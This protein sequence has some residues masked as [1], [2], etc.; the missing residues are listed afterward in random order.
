M[1][2]GISL[3]SA[4]PGASGIEATRWTVE[5][6]RA[7]S[8]AGLTSLT[9][10][11]HH[12][13]G[14]VPYVQNAP[15]LGRLLAEWDARPI[16]C[17]FLVPAWNPVLMAEQIGTLAAMAEGPFIVQTGLGDRHQLAVMGADVPHRGHRLETSVGLVKALL[18]GER[19]DDEEL[20]IRG[21]QIA[22][23]PP[24]EVEWWIGAESTPGLVR[25][26]RLGDAWYAGPTLDAA[27][28]RDAMARYHRA[29]DEEGREPGR[30]ALRKDV[31]IA[32]DHASAVATG[33]ALLDAGY[34]GMTRDQVVVGGPDQVAEQ[35]ARFAEIGFTDVIIRTMTVPQP[36]ALRSI[37]LAGR[38][39][40][41]LSS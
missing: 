37:E 11:D 24:R 19:V 36:D 33:G 22:P 8:A 40:D 27:G 31:F 29:C 3:A 35:L 16:G 2:I 28:A 6:A 30:T 23:L 25:A 13:T 10:G 14:P 21:A 12:G 17:L 15:M 39:A 34:R 26:A 41:L 4:H 38:V 1:R 32:D 7:A 9:L 20:G 18:A 5:R